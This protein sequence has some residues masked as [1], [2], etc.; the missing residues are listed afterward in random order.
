MLKKHTLPLAMAML[1][2]IWPLLSTDAQGLRMTS[3]TI[4]RAMERDTLTGDQQAI[5]PVYE[6]FSLDSVKEDEA[7]A[8]GFSFHLHGW[9]RKD[10]AA[11]DLYEDDPDGDL[12]YGYIDYSAPYNPL[13][14]RF[15]RQHIWAGVTDESVDG[16]SMNCGLGENVAL[17][18]FG[19]LPSEYENT[20]GR[21]GDLTYGGRVAGLFRPTYE[22]GISYQQLRDDQSRME[23]KAGLDFNL[24]AGG[25]ASLSGL[26][27]YSLINDAWRE[28]RYDLSLTLSDFQIEPSYQYFFYQDY[29]GQGD[30]KQNLF[31]FLKDSD[32]TLSIFGVDLL[33]GSIPEFQMGV[34]GSQ[35][36]Y[37]LRDEN[38]SYLGWLLVLR[39]F[40][41]S[42][43]GAEVGH[44]DGETSDNLYD[45]F[46]CYLYWQNPF[47]IRL[48]EFISADALLVTYDEPIYD[49]ERSVQFSL[50]AGSKFGGELLETRISV[51]Y[52]SDPYFEDDLSGIGTLQ[53]N[54]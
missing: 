37:K 49:R 2:W 3:E 38:A 45:L 35:Y 1:C 29:F 31:H 16:L 42:Q 11:G 44:M 6:F 20:N 52:S 43:I 12:I 34:R 5:L 23:E 26:S 9:G 40:K 50:G 18:V 15:G 14:G 21:G 48:L 36:A 39:S 19:G 4:L 27:S 30:S 46:R 28:H 25:W 13:Q 10:L 22:L 32:E 33:F 41:G 24:Q 17:M 53:I 8:G 7:E 51:I 47:Q 54:Y